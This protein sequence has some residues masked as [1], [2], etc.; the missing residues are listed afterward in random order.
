MKTNYFSLG[1]LILL[2]GIFT[3]AGVDILAQEGNAEL[4]T[5]QAEASNSG[6]SEVLA[7][8]EMD[9]P[10]QYDKDFGMQPGSELEKTL[11][12]LSKIDM[13]GDNDYDGVIDNDY[14]PDQGAR[15]YDPPGLQVGVGETTKLVVR[16]KTYEQEFPGDLIIQLTVAGVN[17]FSETGKYASDSEELK[18]IGRIK[19]W[20]EKDKKT[21]LLDSG[22]LD[23]RKVEWK[24]D[25]E[26]LKTGVPDTY[27]RVIYVEGVEVSPKFEG[28]IRLMISSS[29]SV[30]DGDSSVPSSVYRTAFDHMLFTIRKEPIK[31]SFVNDDVEGVWPGYRSDEKSGEDNDS[32]ENGDQVSLE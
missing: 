30:S 27:P 19:V 26:K 5:A 15:E 6:A 11:K 4:S 31:K 17:R 2:V 9:L 21:L 32:P 28:D 8:T 23:N 22:D 13:D 7:Q 10:G 24:V 18:S 3:F 16:Y 14:E 25:K 1:E 29:H 20:A 12:F